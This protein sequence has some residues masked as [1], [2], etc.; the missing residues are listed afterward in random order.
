MLATFLIAGIPTWLLVV[1]ALVIVAVLVFS[2]L[3]RL[4]KLA[5]LVAAIALAVWL[6]LTLFEMFA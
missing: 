6:G 3:K 2:L 5:I 4:F 1:A